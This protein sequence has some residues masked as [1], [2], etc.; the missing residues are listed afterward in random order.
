MRLICKVLIAN[1][2]IAVVKAIRCIRRW[3]YETFGNERVVQFVPM[4]TPED[5]RTNAE[6]IRMA[7]TWIDVPGGSNKYNF[8]NVHFI[9][10]I[11]DRYQCQAVWAGWGHASENPALPTALSAINV[12]FLGPDPRSMH[13]LGD[14]IAPTI[15]AQSAGVLTVAWSGT[16]IT[17]NY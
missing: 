11:G 10:D 13:A 17:C 15:I 2:G 16:G 12:V 5:V 6:Y 8:A 9:A 3:S 7:D 4:A 14:K 1:N